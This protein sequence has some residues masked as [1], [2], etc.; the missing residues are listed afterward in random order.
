MCHPL[1]KVTLNL[2]L[3]IGA[4]SVMCMIKDIHY[5][6]ASDHENS[7]LLEFLT[8]KAFISV[9]IRIF[10]CLYSVDE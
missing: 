9:F 10:P 8:L 1:Q 2:T 6:I 7:K 4:F 5:K 3:L